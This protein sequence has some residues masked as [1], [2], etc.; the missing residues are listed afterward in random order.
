MFIFLFFTDSFENDGIV[1]LTMLGKRPEMGGT[2][3]ANF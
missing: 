2:A 1:F 3:E